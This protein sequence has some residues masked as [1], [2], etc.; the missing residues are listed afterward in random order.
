MAMQLTR[1]RRDYLGGALMLLIGIGA[2]AEGSTYDVGTLTTMGPGFFP[3]ALGVL[4]ALVGLGIIISARLAA[5][6]Q[7][8]AIRKPEW[9][10]WGCILGGVAAF[11]VLGEYGGLIPATFAVVFISALGD[12]SNNMKRAA[13]LALA[14]VAICVVV[15]WWALKLQFPLFSWG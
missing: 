15:F 4:M 3:V 8:Q 13:L 2:L 14:M 11:V 9:L 1:A 7:A 10:A 6:R 12:R 5:P